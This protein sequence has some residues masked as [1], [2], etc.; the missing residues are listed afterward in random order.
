MVTFR[1]REFTRRDT[2]GAVSTLPDR[3]YGTSY[4]LAFGSI[5]R[6]CLRSSDCSRRI[7]FSIILWLQS[8]IP[9]STASPHTPTAP[10]APANFASFQPATV[11]EIT[12]L[13]NSSQNKQCDLDPIPTSL[14]KECLLILAPTITNIVN[15]SLSTGSF[16]SVF[17]QS[18]SRR[19]KEIIWILYYS[20]N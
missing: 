14:L 3:I 12:R 15:I 13:I 18:I 6:V 10:S 11:D 20:R 5:R 19:F 8:A 4:R 9:A 17:K 16:P 7:C 1:F 2:G